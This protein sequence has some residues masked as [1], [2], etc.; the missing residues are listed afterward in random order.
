MR[1]VRT[2][3]VSKSS[4]LLM[5]AGSSG[6]PR[7]WIASALKETGFSDKSNRRKPAADLGGDTL[8]LACESFASA[9]EILF[10]LRAG[11]VVFTTIPYGVFGSEPT[12]AFGFAMTDSEQRSTCNVALLLQL[13]Q[14]IPHLPSSGEKKIS[15]NSLKPLPNTKAPWGNGLAVNRPAPA[16]FCEDITLQ[17]LLS[18]TRRRFFNG[19]NHLSVSFGVP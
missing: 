16:P 8:F 3:P 14:G 17:P 10:T 7:I 6:Y 15:G 13:F 5:F 4:E 1:L 18:S 9:A 11:I 12:L 19:A 2:F